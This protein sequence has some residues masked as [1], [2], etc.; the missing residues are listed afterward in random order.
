MSE[1]VYADVIFNK[2]IKKGERVE[3]VVGTY[4]SPEAVRGHI[5]NVH[6]ED[7]N[8]TRNIQSHHTGHTA[9]NQCYRVTA[10]CVVLL[11]VVLITAVTV[12]WIKHNILKT[13]NNQLQ[14]SYNNLTIERN[15]LETRYT[16]LT[17]ERDQ[18]QGGRAIYLRIF[19]DLDIA[20]YFNSSLYFMY[21]AKKNWTESRQNC[22]DK[23]AD[24]VII[25]SNEEQEFI[26]KQL[27]GSQ[28]WIGLSDRDAEGEWK[29][30]DGTPL[31]SGNWA[32]QQPDNYNNEDCG[33]TGYPDGQ[34]WNDK[35]CS[36]TQAW[37]C[38]KKKNMFVNKILL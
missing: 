35:P 20:W 26:A 21:N 37:I 8:T 28:A 11:C 30:V 1:C 6:A 17:I 18:L 36:Y 32:N 5:L 27:Q 2:E 13:E 7:I 34:H 24:L 15:Q 29:W 22:M 10:V 19:Y 25:N 3:R 16:N 4:E 12:L 9:F 14:T 23:G 38:E 31:T 33:E